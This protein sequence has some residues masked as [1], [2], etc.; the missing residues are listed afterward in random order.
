MRDQSAL[1][2]L[3]IAIAIPEAL[4]L[5]HG[6]GIALTVGSRLTVLCC[7]CNLDLREE[8]REQRQSRVWIEKI[9]QSQSYFI[10]CVTQEN[11]IFTLLCLN[12]YRP[13]Q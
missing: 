2:C 1:S 13:K 7:V 11:L 3:T 10:I 9:K 6:S 4:R 5:C 8:R 12:K